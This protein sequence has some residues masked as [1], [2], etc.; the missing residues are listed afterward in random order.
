MKK[1]VFVIL[2]LLVAAIQLVAGKL[3]TLKEIVTPELLKVHGS[4]AY[5]VQREEIHVFSLKDLSLIRKFG[6]KGE[7]PGEVKVMDLFSNNVTITKDYIMVESL[8]KL[9]YYSLDGIFKKEKRCSSMLVDFY[10]VGDYFL[11]K[12]PKKGKDKKDY[13][14]VAL[15]D[16]NMK[17]VKLLYQQENPQQQ[18]TLNLT[19]DGIHVK[20][21]EDKIFIEE[22]SKGFYFE[23]FDFKGNKLYDIKKPY[24]KIAIDDTEKTKILE[25][26][27][28]ER[29]VKIQGFEKIKKLF[30]FHYS[31]FYPA[32]KDFFISGTQIYVRTYNKKK[33]SN[34]DEFVVMNLQGEILKTI[35]LPHSPDPRVLLYTMLGLGP[36]YYA[37]SNNKFYYL[38]ENEDED[39]DLHVVDLK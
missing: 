26:F 22:S 25:K 27:K 34:E 29:L 32:I 17:K 2:I 1:S 15:L 39:W 38:I 28:E 13:Q 8:D 19:P 12:G 30:N 14:A 37:I 35:Y 11:V 23:V 6:K 10:P 33:D 36:K 7:G 5:I 16:A 20:V 3:G 21:T 4:N 31:S 9:V 18:G 24:V